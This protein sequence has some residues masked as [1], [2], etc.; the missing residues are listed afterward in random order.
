MN[1]L[2]NSEGGVGGFGIMPPVWETH[3]VTIFKT[4]YPA[5]CGAM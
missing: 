5:H 2:V 4:A 3:S 1:Q